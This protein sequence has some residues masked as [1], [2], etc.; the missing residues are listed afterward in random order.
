[1]RPLLPLAF[2]VV[3]AC[4]KTSSNEMSAPPITSSA[5][6]AS[7]SAPPAAS[8]APPATPSSDDTMPKPKPS[9]RASASAPPYELPSGAVPPPPKKIRARVGFATI[10]GTPSNELRAAVTKLLD[11]VRA[12]YAIGLKKDP[13]L[14]GKVVVSMPVDMS[15]HVSDVSDDGSDLPDD[16]AVGCILRE[17]RAIEL[18]PYDAGSLTARAFFILAS[19]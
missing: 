1:M 6:V 11:R 13:N 3:A 18:S 19:G 7:S 9:A 8:S 2:L 12:C 14:I 15:G 16:A 17:L 5:P 4:S 10:N